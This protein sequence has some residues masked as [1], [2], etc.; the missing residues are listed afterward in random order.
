MKESSRSIGAGKTKEKRWQQHPSGDN[1]ELSWSGYWLS[2]CTCFWH[3]QHDGNLVI[4]TMPF[5]TII[6]SYNADVQQTKYPLS[7]CS[8]VLC[9]FTE[10]TEIIGKWNLNTSFTCESWCFT[11]TKA[12]DDTLEKKYVDWTLITLIIIIVCILGCRSC[13]CQHCRASTLPS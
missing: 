2:A 8:V 6:L 1:K 3:L 7:W 12:R 10:W 9:S 5:V 11:Q 13:F 4:V